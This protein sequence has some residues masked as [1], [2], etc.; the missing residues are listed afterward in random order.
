MEK[1]TT[2]KQIKGE[3]TM[4][5]RTMTIKYE[6]GLGGS[7]MKSIKYAQVLAKRTGS[8]LPSTS[9]MMR[10]CEQAKLSVAIDAML[11]GIKVTLQEID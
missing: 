3:T 11:S 10:N 1:E 2:K 5:T 9:Q 8:K 6:R 7:T 4:E